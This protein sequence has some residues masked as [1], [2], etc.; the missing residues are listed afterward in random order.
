M[1]LPCHPKNKLL[2]PEE[3]AKTPISSGIC[4]LP[5]HRARPKIKIL[6]TTEETKILR[7]TQM[8]RKCHA[9]CSVRSNVINYLCDNDRIIP[10]MFFETL[11]WRLPVR[12]ASNL[13]IHN[14]KEVS[15]INQALRIG[16]VSGNLRF[17]LVSHSLI[18]R[19]DYICT[20]RSISSWK[21]PLVATMLSP[22][23]KEVLPL[24]SVTQPPASMTMSA[25]AI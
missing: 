9:F 2:S 14:E 7:V 10:I 5:L 19:E 24:K 8:S 22:I 15:W 4:E 11:L 23:V 16:G 1:P 12:V 6:Y 20:K 3:S 21:H 17:C 25:A 13:Y 18:N